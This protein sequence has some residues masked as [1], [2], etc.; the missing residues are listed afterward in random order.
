MGSG[1]RRLAFTKTPDYDY[2]ILDTLGWCS[3]FDDCLIDSFTDIDECFEA[4]SDKYGDVLYAV[5]FYDGGCCC[6]DSC[7]YFACGTYQ[8]AVVSGNTVN[9]W[10]GESGYP[11]TLRHV[12]V[13][14][15]N[16]SVCEAAYGSSFDAEY[17]ICAGEAEGGVDSCQGDSGGPLVINTGS[18]FSQI[19]VVSWGIGCADPGYYGVYGEIAAEIDFITSVIDGTYSYD[20]S[21]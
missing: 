19:G 14:I 15:V 2:E 6:Q 18:G 13:P 9:A 5:D 7:D 1:D 20:Y 21:A 8:T 3:G 10:C 17:E 16:D 4:C 12:E 11:D